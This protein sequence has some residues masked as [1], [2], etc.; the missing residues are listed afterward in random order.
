MWQ[1]EGQ[2]AMATLDHAA[3][4]DQDLP[5]WDGIWLENEAESGNQRSL[6]T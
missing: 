5:V 6:P 1:E 3:Q 4:S 2:R